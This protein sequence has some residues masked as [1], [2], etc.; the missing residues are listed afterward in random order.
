ME[1]I[2]RL[3]RKLRYIIT[4]TVIGNTLEWYDFALF[5]LMA[6][7]LGKL[8]FP[9]NSPNSAL[10]HLLVFFALGALARPIGGLVFGYIGDK[11]GRKT[12][13]IYA[14]ILMTISVALISVLPSYE[15]IGVTATV[16]LAI[17]C[18]IQGFCTG[19]E[20]AGSIVFLT[21]NAPESKKGFA[22]SW[23]YFGAV[24]GMLLSALDIYLVHESISDD[25]FTHWGW[26]IPFILGVGLGLIG[27]LLRSFLNETPLFEEAKGMGSIVREPILSSLHKYKKHLA[28]GIGLFFLDA[29]GFNLIIVYCASYF[30]HFLGYTIG[31][32]YTINCLTVLVILI[33]IPF[34]GT[35]VMKWGS[36]K[37]ATFSAWTFFFFAYP[38]YFLISTGDIRCL[39][40]GQGILALTLA[41]YLASL[42]ELVSRLFPTQVRYSS[43]AITTNLCVAIFGGTAPLLN[44]YLIDLFQD[45]ILPGLYLMGGALVSCWTLFNFMNDFEKQ[46]H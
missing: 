10:S 21:E 29:V 41:F 45:P 46:T 13:L 5:S 28:L 3:S 31:E 39:I 42:P 9:E 8:F 25:E 30:S 26:R 37:V 1:T 2:P 4:A 6:P 43:V 33:G 34:G 32:A 14:I 19:G 40:A 7:I 44:T 38:L 11:I 35:L 24:L 27:I 23:A 15:Q 16:T 22:G 20:F 36:Q 17:I 12:A 18:V